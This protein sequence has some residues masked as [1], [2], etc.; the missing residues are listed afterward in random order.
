MT[1]VAKIIT[2]DKKVMSYE[3]S[4]SGMVVSLNYFLTKTPIQSRLFV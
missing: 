2:S 1:E 3:F 4:D